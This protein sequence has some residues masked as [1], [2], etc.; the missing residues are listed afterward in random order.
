MAGPPAPSIWGPVAFVT[1][2]TGQMLSD[3]LKTRLVE[4]KMLD[5]PDGLAVAMHAASREIVQLFLP[6]LTNDPTVQ[7]AA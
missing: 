2:R 3:I 7:Q 4:L 5:Q 6:A 1:R